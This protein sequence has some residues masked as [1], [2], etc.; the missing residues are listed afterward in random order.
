LLHYLAKID[1][2]GEFMSREDEYRRLA[3][4]CFDLARKAASIA[5]RT[6]LLVMAEGWLDLIDRTK[7]LAKHQISAPQH[8]QVNSTLAAWNGPEQTKDSNSA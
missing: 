6:R 8:Q 2:D 5:D 4:S 1:S 7:R 3:A